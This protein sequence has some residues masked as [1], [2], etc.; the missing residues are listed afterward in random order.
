MYSFDRVLVDPTPAVLKRT[1][2]AAAATANKGLRTKKLAWPPDDLRSFR[3]ELRSLAEGQHQWTG[4][5]ARLAVA[6]WSD[7]LGRKHYRIVAHRGCRGDLFQLDTD[8]YREGRERPVLWRVYPDD[9]YLKEEKDER[10]LWA[11][12]RCGVA[13][14]PEE[15]GW[16]GPWCGACHDR[17]EEGH[18]PG[19]ARPASSGHVHWPS[20]LGWR[21][22]VHS[23]RPHFAG[24]CALPSRGVDV[25]HS[26]RRPRKARLSWQKGEHPHQRTDHL[27]RRP[28]GRGMHGRPGAYLV[29]GRWL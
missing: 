3:R 14:P 25:G 15:V 1:M 2:T 17:A 4:R 18:P 21:C 8:M 13:G 6:W 20:L 9:L 11:V 29:P 12:C 22:C 23:R 24:A 28:D 7:L 27:R 19:A 10:P 5:D 26:H 16:V